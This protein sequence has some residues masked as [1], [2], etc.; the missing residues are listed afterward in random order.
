MSA[1]STEQE[2][3][4]RPAARRPGEGIEDLLG[5][6]VL[7]WVG[8]A[9]VLVG[10]ALFFALAITRGWIGQGER[11]VLAGA[12]SVAMLALGFWLHERR[13]RTDA[14]LATVGVSIAAGFMTLL[15]AC[16]VYRVLPS[17]A[18][19]GLGFGLGA[20]AT[21]L[22]VRWDSRIIAALGM[23]GAL[24]APVLVDAPAGLGTMAL[25]FA[26]AASATAVVVRKRWSWLGFAVVLVGA[27]QWVPWAVS[28][29][30]ASQ[31]IAVLVF[32]AALNVAAAIGFELRMPSVPVR[33]S[34]SFLLV[35]NALIVSLVGWQV[36]AA[37]G[38]TLMAKAFL[39]LL[40]ASHLAI[41]LSTHRFPRVAREL[42]L[43]VLTLGVILADV[44]FGV[45]VS[46]PSLALGWGIAGVAFAALLRSR[47]L[48]AKRVDETLTGLGLGAHLALALVHTLVVVTPPALLSGEM[49][50][51]GLLALAVVASSCFVSARLAGNGRLLVRYALDGAGLAVVAYLMAFALDGPALVAAWAGEA[52]ALALVAR[53]MHDP[54]ALAGAGGF[55]GFAIGHTLALEAPLGSV[56]GG[57]PSVGAAALAIGAVAL[58]TWRIGSLRLQVPG[59]VSPALRAASVALVGYGAAVI[60]GGAWLVLAW[61]GMAIAL[62]VLAR[63]T[64]DAIPEAAAAGLIGAGALHTLVFEAPAVPMD[65][66][67]TSAMAA[68]LAL[69]SLAVSALASAALSRRP[70]VTVGMF[71][72]APAVVAYG[73]AALFEGWWVGLGWAFGAL[74]L[75]VLSRRLRG[76]IA[77]PAALGY[78]GLA[79]GHA[80]LVDAP[81]AALG[82][83][84]R[85]M[86]AAAL[87]L[88]LAGAA[89]YVLSRTPELSSAARGRLLALAGLTALWLASV[90]VVSVFAPGAAGTLATDLGRQAG[91][92]ALSML[93]ALAGVGA[94]LVGLRRDLRPLRL[95]ALAL[96]G[97]TVG[98]VFLLD[99]ATLD[100]V[101]RVGSFIALGLLLLA[102]A[103][104]YQRLRP[105]PLPDLRAVPSGVR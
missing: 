22:A 65:G 24:L 79:L 97:V 30:Q 103:F 17:P 75:A 36:L 74:A 40:A 62:A 25:L 80:V 9:T 85:N 101:Y 19:L 14:A 49:T 23:V 82:D 88:G 38:H 41:G 57:P 67:Q 72:G 31:A 42:R 78:L 18:G 33:V 73:I 66:A 32:F 12:G 3:G 81:W 60:L 59:A 56:F 98:K 46:G 29:P 87:V 21:A 16:E 6:R 10:C 93:W 51:G 35:L 63:I 105:R 89:A 43:V 94:L 76:R 86:D 83:G 64:R 84:L 69:G 54:V 8:G 77:L 1:T 104:G 68:S 52:V 27:A 92:M 39:G 20:I 26:A 2:H 61:A 37:S 90:E 96:L 53:R 13:G 44:T 4:Q 7:A 5:G 95:A 99:L 11:C 70:Q 28:A 47:A 100:S 50:G 55:L 34:A 71:S 58:A 15:V 45:S 48:H 102:G 91:Q